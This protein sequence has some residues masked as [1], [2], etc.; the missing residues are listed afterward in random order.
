M[1]LLHLADL[2]LGKSLLEAPLLEDQAA[3][4]KDVCDYAAAYEVNAVL[5]SGDLYDRTVPP[6]EAV[7]LFDRFLSALSDRNIPVLAITGNHDSPERLSFGSRLFRRSGV[8]I[9][10]RCESP[11]SRVRLEDSFGPV[12]FT[13]LPFVRPAAVRALLSPETGRSVREETPELST[14]QQAVA[15]VLSLRPPEQGIRQV[16]LAHQFVCAGGRTPETCDSDL[17]QAG[18]VEAVDV[19]CFDGYDYVALGHLH[20]PQRVGRDTVRYAGSPLKYSLSEVRHQKSF[21]LVTLGAGGVEDI[22]LVPFSPPHDL[23]RI[24]GELEELLTAG[25]S[26]GETD[27]YL[28]A[29]LTGEREADPA[30]RLR[31]VYPRLLHVEYELTRK[32]AGT[33]ADSPEGNHPSDSK[34]PLQLFEEFYETSADHPLTERQRDILAE[35]MSH[36]LRRQ[37]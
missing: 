33:E 26:S 30:G 31:A 27:N 25:K 3:V 6:A 35:V 28:W 16:L 32:G 4:L 12:D 22:E 34:T 2:H 23:R 17:P 1:K 7:E 15:A 18:G 14:T 20:R 24:R 10:G 9:A 5:L 13:L 8:H 11:L 21:P 37:D 36:I 29:V 19:S